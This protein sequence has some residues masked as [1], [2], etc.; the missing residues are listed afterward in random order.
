MFWA[1]NSNLYFVPAGSSCLQ[2]NPSR[3]ISSYNSDIRKNYEFPGLR[4]CSHEQLPLPCLCII[5]VFL[6]LLVHVQM[7]NST[8]TVV[9]HALPGALQKA[10]LFPWNCLTLFLRHIYRKRGRPKMRLEMMLQMLHHDHSNTKI[11]VKGKLPQLE[12]IWS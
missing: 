10:S 2:I 11:N 4:C 12:L 7:Y 9:F 1:N 5:I 6:A 8:L 3:F